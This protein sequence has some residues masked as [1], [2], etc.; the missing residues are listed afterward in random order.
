MSRYKY[1]RSHEFIPGYK[2]VGEHLSDRGIIHYKFVFSAGA[3]AESMTNNLPILSVLAVV[4]FFPE[5]PQ[6]PQVLTPDPWQL[7]QVTVL[8]SCF[9]LFSFNRSAVPDPPHAGHGILPDPL[10]LGHGSFSLFIIHTF[11]LV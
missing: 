7:A 10:H 3:K 1:D 6:E 8:F 2:I 11:W 4:Y 5:P 9:S